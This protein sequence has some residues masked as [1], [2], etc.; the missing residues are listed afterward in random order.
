M[1]RI[2]WNEFL[3]GI[4]ETGNRDLSRCFLRLGIRHFRAERPPPV[5]GAPVGNQ[6]ELGLDRVL[7]YLQL[8]A[9]QAPFN[10]APSSG[11][12]TVAGK[13]AL[14]EVDDRACLSNLA[15]SGGYSSP[16][17]RV[18]GYEDSRPP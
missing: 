17:G 9:E 4:D 16:C 18:C 13:S 11:S 8:T 1:E 12:S 10:A 3:G 5:P 6:G 14:I 15:I 2:S 7:L